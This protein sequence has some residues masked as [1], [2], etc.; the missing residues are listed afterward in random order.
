[1]SDGPYRSLP[2]RP[3]WKKVAEWVENENFDAHQVADRLSQAVLKDF[4]KEVPHEAVTLIQSVFEAGETELFPDQRSL[5]L[6]NAR[7]LLEGSPLGSLFLDCAAQELAEGKVGLEGITN[8]ARAAIGDRVQRAA[9]Q[10]EE[11]YFRHPNSS[12]ELAVSVRGR[13]QEAISH[14]PTEDIAHRI[15]GV[16]PVRGKGAVRYQGLDDGVQIS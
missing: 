1:M 13:L 10:I 3:A 8:A 4:R 7:R 6:S 11:H 15:L 2:M 12:R 14:T 9:R 5:D 16:N